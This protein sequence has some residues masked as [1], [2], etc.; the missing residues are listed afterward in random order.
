[1]WFSLERWCMTVWFLAVKSFNM[2]Q[3]F[4][5]R[6]AY[7]HALCVLCVCVCADNMFEDNL[8]QEVTS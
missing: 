7:M 8:M 1:M 6:Q 2:H 3:L 5:T 4:M